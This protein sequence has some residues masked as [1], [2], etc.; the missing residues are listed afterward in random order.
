MRVDVELAGAQEL[1]HRLAHARDGILHLE[2]QLAPQLEAATPPTVV[3][4]ST[5]MRA[6]SWGPGDVWTLPA[7][8][9]LAPRVKL[10]TD[11]DQLVDQVQDLLNG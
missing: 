7:G 8:G 11:L 9:W 2:E 3:F 10:P 4:D 6:R 1:E 5:A